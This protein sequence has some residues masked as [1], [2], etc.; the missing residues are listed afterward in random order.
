MGG[1]LPY[2]GGGTSRPDGGNPPR[3]GA[4]RPRSPMW[5]SV[6]VLF[7]PRGMEAPQAGV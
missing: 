5:V 7:G 1:T 6:G 4:G 2:E 3:G